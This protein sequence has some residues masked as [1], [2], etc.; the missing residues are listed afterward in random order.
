MLMQVALPVADVS[1]WGWSHPRL[2]ARQLAVPRRRLLGLRAGAGGDL[3]RAAA[4]DGP[5]HHRAAHPDRAHC[6][7]GPGVSQ[8]TFFLLQ[9]TAQ[10]PYVV[11]ARSVQPA[12]GFASYPLKLTEDDVDQ[13]V[14]YTNLQVMVVA[15]GG[16][17]G[18]YGSGSL[19]GPSGS[20]SGASGLL[21]GS[22]GSGSGSG[23]GS[24]GG[25][26]GGAISTTCCPGV[27]WPA[28]LHGTISCPSCPEIDGVSFE[29]N[30]SGTDGYGNPEWVTTTV[31]VV[32]DT[33][34][35]NEFTLR[36]VSA[37]FT[38]LGWQLGNAT[39]NCYEFVAMPPPRFLSVRRPSWCSPRPS[40][41]EGPATPARPAST[42]KPSPARSRHNVPQMHPQAGK[43]LP[44]RRGL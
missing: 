22:G 19:S 43:G 5:P 23:S 38:P 4:G 1:S 30:Y 3:R 15:A 28:T 27:P 6:Q 18:S 20:G 37:G 7:V 32:P 31:I 25:S 13:I 36:C 34:F 35:T 39:L 9:G 14:D 26:G 8:L 33:G 42:A 44:G 12:P 29:L 40:R 21:S 41:K 24:G 17:E 2:P 16:G 10:G 11:A